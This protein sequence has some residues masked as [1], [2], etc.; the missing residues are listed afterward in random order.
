MLDRFRVSL[1]DWLWAMLNWPTDDWRE[2]LNRFVEHTRYYG[3]II[4]PESVSTIHDL[5]EARVNGTDAFAVLGPYGAKQPAGTGPTVQLAMSVGLD[6]GTRTDASVDLTSGPTPTVKDGAEVAGPGPETTKSFQDKVHTALAIMD[7]EVAIWWSR[8]PGEIRSR[9]ASSWTTFLRSNEKTFV[10]NR[11]PVVLVDENYTVALTAA[12]IINGTVRMGPFRDLFDRDRIPG[13]DEANRYAEAQQ[14][15]IKEGAAFAG[16]LA[17]TYYNAVGS[18]TPAGDVVV[19]IDDVSQHGF[20][21]DHLL[22]VLPF[23]AYFRRG[24]KSLI[25][26]LPRG[27]QLRLSGEVLERLAKLDP[28][29]R[30]TLIAKARAAKTEEEGLAI[31]ER[32]AAGH[33]VLLQMELE[34]PGVGVSITLKPGGF[35]ESRTQDACWTG[36]VGHFAA[37]PGREGVD[38]GSLRSIRPAA[39]PGLLL[40]GS[41]V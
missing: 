6:D 1:G 2:Q 31:I 19:T 28:T 36:E 21:W 5:I 10:E 33:S 29:K 4:E 37:V 25:I 11:K 17:E 14:E 3:L 34:F 26:K 38:L 27:K 8:A 12:A 7:A 9:A 30:N 35:H 18:L 39:Q 24:A 32:G 23:M 41:T 22:I 40:A 15:R 16:W 20:R 13:P